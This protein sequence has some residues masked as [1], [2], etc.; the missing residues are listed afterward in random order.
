MQTPLVER[1]NGDDSDDVWRALANRTRR[2]ILD[3]LRSG[4]ATTGD[5][6]EAIGQERHITLQH[7]TVLRTA[8]LVTVERQGRRKINYLNPVPIQAIHERW[9]S[10]YEAS[11]LAALVGLK[12]AV[13][14]Q[15]PRAEEG[16]D[17]G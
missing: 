8:G 11:W 12:S 1:E 5:L 7:L 3:V 6:V 13:E 10:Q 16:R 14:Q 17:V 9:V 2:A 15:H 4:P